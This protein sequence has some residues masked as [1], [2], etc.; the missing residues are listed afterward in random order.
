VVTIAVKPFASGKGTRETACLL[1]L[2]SIKGRKK[3]TRLPDSA[4]IEKKFWE[5][6]KHYWLERTKPVGELRRSISRND[7]GEEKGKY[8]T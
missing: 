7:R 6:A 2:V 5:T 1:G 8:R 3:K 4:E